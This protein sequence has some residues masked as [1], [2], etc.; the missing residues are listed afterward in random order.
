MLVEYNATKTFTEA[1]E[2]DDIGN[3]AIICHG[4]YRDGKIKL[5]GDYAIIIKTIMGIATILK[6]GPIVDWAL[7]LQNGYNVSVKTINFKEPSLVREIQ[8][9]INDPMKDIREAEVVDGDSLLD[10]LPKLENYVATL[11]RAD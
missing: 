9:F 5:P 2:I 1:L 4:F 8:M 11:E 6:W 3:C 7:G 10:F